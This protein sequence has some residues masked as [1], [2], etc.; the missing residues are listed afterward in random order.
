MS[1]DVGIIGENP[2]NWGALGSTLCDEGRA[3]PL[4]R[5]PHNVSYHTGFHPL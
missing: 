4:K 5:A 3:D 2:Q 1:K